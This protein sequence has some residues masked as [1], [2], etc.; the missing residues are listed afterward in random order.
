MA[1]RQQTYQT[2]L[3]LEEFVEE[4]YDYSILWV[5]RP[6]ACV[7]ISIEVV[8]Q[9]AEPQ[10]VQIKTRGDLL[11]GSPIEIEYSSN[12][13]I[14][15]LYHR[16]SEWCP[17]EYQPPNTLRDVILVGAL[18][19]H[20]AVNEDLSGDEPAKAVGDEDDWTAC[21]SATG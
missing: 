12:S 7:K 3:R 10:V 1:V 13:L 6:D 18:R 17:Q 15:T 20:L 11:A 19:C 21:L 14:Q 8:H 2:E 5:P 16:I 4:K 9:P